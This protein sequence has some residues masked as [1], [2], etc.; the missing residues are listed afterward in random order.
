MAG[1]AS[2]IRVQ[3]AKIRERR[4]LFFVMYILA[5]YF[6]FLTVLFLLKRTITEFD[7]K[8]GIV[9]ALQR[10]FFYG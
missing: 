9:K 3:V 7:R 10:V 2:A 6:Y 1:I 5:V 8:T 4:Y